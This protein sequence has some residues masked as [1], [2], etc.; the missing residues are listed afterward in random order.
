MTSFEPLFWEA[1]GMRPPAAVLTHPS[2]L[3]PYGGRGKSSGTCRSL[4]VGTDHIRSGTG[5]VVSLAA[6]T[7]MSPGKW[8]TAKKNPTYSERGSHCDPFKM[9]LGQPCQNHRPLSI[10]SV[11]VISIEVP[12]GAPEGTGRVNARWVSETC[13]ISL[14]GLGDKWAVLA[15]AF[16]WW[17]VYLCTC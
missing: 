14:L 13:N 12:V 11:W 8:C 2:S 3:Q 7:K 5:Q 6:P 16:Q 1:I 10:K 15:G 4:R 17:S 9:N